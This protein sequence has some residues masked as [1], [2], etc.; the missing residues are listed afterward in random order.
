[1]R[2][3]MMNRDSLYL[4]LDKA[5]LIPWLIQII[6]FYKYVHQY[7]VMDCLYVLICNFIEKCNTV[8]FIESRNNLISNPDLKPEKTIDYEIGFQQV[9]TK[10]SSL[11]KKNR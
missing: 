6:H 5:F 7:F 4:L 11:K 8:L 9:L 2:V 3:S 10:T 1:M